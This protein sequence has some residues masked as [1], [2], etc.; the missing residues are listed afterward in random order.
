[1][2]KQDS[3]YRRFWNKVDRKAANQCWNWKGG[4]G[5]KGYG[6]LGVDGKKVL[7]HRFAYEN[8]RGDIP[9]GMFV[10]H[11]CD[12]RACVNPIH[13][14]LGT[15]ADNMADR[16]AKG[17]Q[18]KLKGEANGQAKLSEANIVEIKKRITAGETQRAI[19]FDYGVAQSQIS[20]VKDGRTWQS[21][22]A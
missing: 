21:V 4:K 8:W 15:H 7:V 2:N 22:N 9:D 12:N 3:P 16:N 18:A 11:K 6:L 13:L 5:G 14:F 17:R 19:A 10:C 20:R 1:M